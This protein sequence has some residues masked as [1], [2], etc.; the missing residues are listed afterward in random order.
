MNNKKRNTIITIVVIVI[1]FL[2]IG[3]YFGLNYTSDENALTVVEKKWITNN[4]NSVVDV[5]VYND[6]PV[7]GYNGDGI[8]FGFL[9][10]VTEEID[11]KFNKIS[12]YTDSNFSETSISF[13]VVDG[14]SSIG[15]QDV[16]LY[17]DHYVILADNSTSGIKLDDS[18]KLGILTVNKEMAF[19]YFPSNIECVEYE[20]IDKLVMALKNGEV[21]YILLASLGN[22][23]DML[24]NDL[25]IVYHA[26]DLKK[27]YILRTKDEVVYSIL[28]KMYN[29]YLDE[30]YDEDYTKNYLNVYY[31][32]TNTS[33]LLQKNYNAKTYKYGYVINM[34]YENYVNNQFVGTVLNY[35]ELLEEETG[36]E[37]ETLIYSNIDNLKSALVSGEVDFALGNFNYDNINFE[38]VVTGPISDLDYVVVSKN[39]YEINSLKGLVG[40]DVSVVASS[41]LH[42][43]LVS[44]GGTPVKYSNT[45]EMLRDIDDYSIVLLDKQTYIY[46]Q[47]SKLK[48]YNVILEGTIKDGY[49]F[50]L[51]SS[52][53]P[54]NSL[55]SHFV[56]TIDYQTI[57]YN[58]H[59][60]VTLDKDYTS[61]KIF[62][63]IVVLI[64]ILI[65]T[66]LLMNKKSVTNTVIT[67]DEKL[68]YID[69]MT[70]LKNRNYLNLNIYKWDDNVI[71]P[72]SVVVM[73]INRLRE[74]NDTYG[75]E[76]GDEIIKRVASV[77]INNQLENTD[78]IRSGGDEFLIYMV[79]YEEKRVSEYTKKLLR[80]MK[81]I[82]ESLGVEV[83]YSMILDEVKTVDDAI[84]EAIIMMTKNKEKKRAKEQE[85]KQ[86]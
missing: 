23:D 3:V 41:L 30:E 10:Y 52:N 84:N 54:F 14:D 17:Q 64:I 16:L 38:H 73:D 66:I 25:K 56:S 6:I 49:K 42:Q 61:I 40:E 48:D 65:G 80:D 8:I 29:E 58:Y 74:I 55:F 50:I 36:A 32:S 43:E 5:N 26:L 82:P 12:Y 15:E 21:N 35:L 39:N 19:E 57:R 51:N 76:A 18:F 34:P 70:S 60:D 68:K 75:R 7:Y 85:G 44:N 81:D 78:I 22:M 77:L 46:Y 83:G 79:G 69:P 67:K 59:T 37:I 2:G 71:F 31:K 1:I 86:E 33:D 13:Q 45:D 63:F 9:E 24:A 47:A 28:K 11:M 53:E 27:N 4:L 20:D 62:G 72:Q